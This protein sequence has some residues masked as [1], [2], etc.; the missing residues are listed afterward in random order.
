MEQG[1]HKG[2]SE[3]LEEE[4]GAVEEQKSIKKQEAFRPYYNKETVG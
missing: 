3:T 4:D 2:S 1:K